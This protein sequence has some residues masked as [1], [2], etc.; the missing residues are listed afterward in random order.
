[1]LIVLMDEPEQIDCDNGF[2]VAT[3]DGLTV[4]VKVIGVPLQP[5]TDMGVTVI[6]ATTDVVPLFTGVNEGILPDPLDA[7]PMEG[8]SLDQL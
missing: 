4:I 7:S 2:A 5:L 3:G 1:M 8:L 6:C